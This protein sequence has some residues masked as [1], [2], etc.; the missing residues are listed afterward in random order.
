[1]MDITYDKMILRKRLK[2]NRKVKKLYMYIIVCMIN[3]EHWLKI[4]QI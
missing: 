2:I 1:M 3:Y 4:D